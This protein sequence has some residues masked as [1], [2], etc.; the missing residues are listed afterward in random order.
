MSDEQSANTVP[1]QGHRGPSY[2]CLK[3]P[4]Q[5]GGPSPN[6]SGRPKRKPMSDAFLEAILEEVEDFYRID[7][8]T[9]RELFPKGTTWLRVIAKAVVR[10]AA[11]GNMK[12]VRE[13]REAIEGRSP[14]R[15]EGVR[16]VVAP[17]DMDEFTAALSRLSPTDRSL[18]IAASSKLV[19]LT[20][21]EAADL[22]SEAETVA[23]DEPGEE[24]AAS[25]GDAGTGPQAES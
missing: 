25:A 21:M 19:E 16:E 15:I 23:P 12:A 22:G 4:W 20:R 1:E 18:M 17:N 2:G 6:P 24:G 11:S 7:Q 8:R 10:L 14:I 3:E 9:N 5:P 13:L